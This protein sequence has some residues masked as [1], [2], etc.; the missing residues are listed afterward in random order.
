[1]TG[2]GRGIVVELW[3]Q[4]ANV[5]AVS[6]NL[7]NLQ[8]LKEKYPS[9]AI[10]AVDLSDWENTRV[11]IDSLGVFHGLVNCAGIAINESFLECTPDT[12]DK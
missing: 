9:I 6:N 8:K 3:R 10:V 2:I 12:F 7:E 1:M 11:V 4:G 5:V